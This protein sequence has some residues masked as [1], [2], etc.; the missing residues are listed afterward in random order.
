MG[1]KPPGPPAAFLEQPLISK[2]ASTTE[3][4]TG[5]ILVDGRRRGTISRFAPRF[6][7]FN[8]ADGRERGSGR[9]FISATPCRPQ[10]GVNSPRPNAAGLFTVSLNPRAPRQSLVLV[11]VL[12]LVIEM[13]RSRTRTRT[14][15]G[16]IWFGFPH[17]PGRCAGWTFSTAEDD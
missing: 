8:L 5:A 2:P 3:A 14:R 7:G 9:Q 15:T 11:V 17:P 13:G 1:G 6:F 10:G 12:V 16:T 4:M